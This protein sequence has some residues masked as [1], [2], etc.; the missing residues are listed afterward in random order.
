MG[1][2]RMGADIWW[3]LFGRWPNGEWRGWTLVR[4][5]MRRQVWRSPYL[6]HDSFGKYWAR[7]TLCKHPDPKV[8]SDPNEPLW[9]H[10]FRCERK[11]NND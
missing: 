8:V 1:A 10:C 11:L 2:A 9:L 7:L 3:L 4:R 5:P 6:W